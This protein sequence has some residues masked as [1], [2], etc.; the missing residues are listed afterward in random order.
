MGEILG[1]AERGNALK[2][3]PKLGWLRA[4]EGDGLQDGIRARI[5]GRTAAT[6]LY[7]LPIVAPNVVL[8]PNADF[9]DFSQ[10]WIV[11]RHLGETKVRSEESWR[12]GKEP[13]VRPEGRRLEDCGTIVRQCQRRLHQRV[14]F[15]AEGFKRG[16]LMVGGRQRDIH[17]IDVGI[18]QHVFDATI[19]VHLG[20]VPLDE[21]TPFANQIADGSNLIELGQALQRRKMVEQGSPTKPYE[22]NAQ[23]RALYASLNV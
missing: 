5:P 1:V 13:S 2:F 3:A 10:T 18:V 8:P 12:V 19:S 23:R 16:L 15:M 14:L 20:I 9:V 7:A 22:R 11:E 6:A 4:H 21:R 17:E